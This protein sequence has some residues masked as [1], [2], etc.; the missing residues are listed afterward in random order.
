MSKVLVDLSTVM[1]P[2]KPYADST[3]QNMKKSELINYV[4]VLEKNHDTAVAALNQ[5]A[6]NVKDWAPVVHAHWGYDSV[7]PDAIVCSKCKTGFAVWRHERNGFNYCPNCGAK[8][9]E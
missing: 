1:K 2:Q 9:D 4:R 7:I 8:M 5:Q 6:E 3:L